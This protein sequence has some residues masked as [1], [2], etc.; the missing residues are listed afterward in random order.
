MFVNRF[1]NIFF[2]FFI[3]GTFAQ[4]RVGVVLGIMQF[5]QNRG[6][7]VWKFFSPKRFFE[8]AEFCEVCKFDPPTVNVV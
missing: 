8:F 4:K 1:F 5:A 6:Y 7:G 3:F 2:S